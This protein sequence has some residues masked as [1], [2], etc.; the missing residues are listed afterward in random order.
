MF[1]TGISFKNLKDTFW[2]ETSFKLLA[3]L[4]HQAQ[5]VSAY[6]IP[7]T[8]RPSATSVNQF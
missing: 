1:I 4:T 2:K 3:H 7:M 8:G 6:S 5:K